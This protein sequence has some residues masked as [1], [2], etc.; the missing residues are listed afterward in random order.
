MC[1]ALNLERLVE[2][3]NKLKAM[4]A[5]WIGTPDVSLRSPLDRWYG[6]YKR[7]EL[8]ASDR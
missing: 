2:L 1:W 4:V 6:Q 3:R 7:Y 8:S 5:H